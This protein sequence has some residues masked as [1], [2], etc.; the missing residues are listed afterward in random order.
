VLLKPRAFLH[1]LYN[2]G[3]QPSYADA[4]STDPSATDKIDTAFDRQSSFGLDTAR[5][6]DLLRVGTAAIVAETVIRLCQSADGPVVSATTSS[7]PRPAAAVAMLLLVV[8]ESAAQLVISSALAL[9]ILYY[10]TWWPNPSTST[11]PD[12]RQVH[13]R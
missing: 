11:L 6:V 10:R 3:H 12:G 1:L 13:F 2:R 9:F 5:R 7:A 8:L 4:G